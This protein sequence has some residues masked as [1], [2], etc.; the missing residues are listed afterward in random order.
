MLMSAVATH[1]V[2]NCSIAARPEKLHLRKE[3]PLN[4]KDIDKWLG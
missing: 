2:Q 3:S 4:E 1:R